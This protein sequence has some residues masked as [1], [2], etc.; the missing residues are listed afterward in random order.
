MLV[1]RQGIN[2]H[3]RIVLSKNIEFVHIYSDTF[4][5]EEVRGKKK[6]IVSTI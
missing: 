2:N 4:K 3:P 1:D 5:S 6:K